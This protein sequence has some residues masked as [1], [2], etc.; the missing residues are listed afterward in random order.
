MPP[1]SD[2]DLARILLSKAEGDEAAFRQLLGN[3][4]IPEAIVG[5]HAQQAIEKALKAVLAA[6]AIHYPKIHD[7]ER[8]VMLAQQTGL[9]VPEPVATS[10]FLTAWATEFRYE[11]PLD[12]RIDRNDAIERVGTALEWARAVI[13]PGIPPKE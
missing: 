8:L 4:D 10:H 11:D 5:F 9:D 3:D 13:G 6:R 2:L 12:Q 1:R 7:L